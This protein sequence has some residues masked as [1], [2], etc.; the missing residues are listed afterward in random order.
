MWLP[1]ESM[2][3]QLIGGIGIFLFGIKYMGDGLQKTAGDRFRTMLERW[4]SRPVSGVLA[5]MAAAIL[6]QSGSGTTILTLGLISA[7]VLSLRQA[8]PVIMGANIGTAVTV[9][10]IGLQIGSF[11]LPVMAA[12][13][14]MLFFMKKKTGIH[15]GQMVFGFGALFLGLDLFESGLSRLGGV[16]FIHEITAGLSGN[17]LLSLI[18]GALASAVLQSSSAA[19]GLLQAVHAQGLISL[20][21]A[22]PFILGDNL[23]T[24]LTVLLASIGATAAAR[25][26][27]WVHGVFNAAGVL[28]CLVFLQPFIALT[29]AIQDALSLNP[30]I[31]LAAAYGLFNLLNLALQL[32]FISLHVRLA[33]FL[34]KD[35][36]HSGNDFSGSHLDPVFIEQSPAI[37]LGQ[38][39][40]EIIQMGYLAVNG[41]K[42]AK[43]YL[44]SRHKLHADTVSGIEEK[45]NQLDRDIA[46]YLVRVT[47]TSLSYAES[48]KISV[49]MDCARDMERVGDHVENLVE[50][51]DSLII[52]KVF[53]SESAVE[54][55][56]EIFSLA[57]SSLETAVTAFDQH[58]FAHAREV[59]KNE[60]SIDRMERFLRKKHTL[61]MNEGS[62]GAQAGII[63]VDILTNIERI[64][65]HA[66][67]LAEAA[68]QMKR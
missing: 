38:A 67:N 39:K 35:R 51:V 7:G 44:V 1:Y 3:F 59:I 9:F 66:V 19:A 56:K 23:G 22:I 58:E 57:I 49:L 61:R 37:A 29:A 8:I 13:S 32:P 52:N 40:E 54:D 21:D 48:E 6:L 16:G 63:F 14:L 30:Y 47:S 53:L 46:D 42:E 62:C 55:L 41:L 26:G 18:T 65:D 4:T 68:L 11:S 12:G 50:L 33:S 24:S 45:I 36:H 64:G 27:A 15:I 43:A 25:R 10:A 31:T 34:A 20:E 2:W 60:E 28:L 17:P 5:G